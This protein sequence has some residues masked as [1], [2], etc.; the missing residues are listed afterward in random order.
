RRI[1]VFVAGANPGAVTD[2]S[3][4]PGGRA[5][6]VYTPP[7]LETVSRVYFCSVLLSVMAALGTDAPLESVMNPLR[8]AVPTCAGIGLMKVDTANR[9]IKKRLRKPKKAT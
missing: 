2:S 6:I 9:A 8:L 7:L 4:S 5:G 1:P 3:Y